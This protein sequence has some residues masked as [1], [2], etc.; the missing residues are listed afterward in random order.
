[1]KTLKDPKV[2]ESGIKPAHVFMPLGSAILAN[3]IVP[4]VGAFL[5][6]GAIG[7]LLSLVWDD[8]E[9]EVKTRI[10]VF[11]SF[12]FDEDVM[13]VQ[14]IRNIGSFDG[15][16]PVSPNEW[17]EVEQKGDKAIK[18]WIDEN[19]K[20][21]RCV[22]VLIGEKTSSSK[23]VNYEIERAWN[24]GK[25]LL[26]VHV[27]NLKCPK[28]GK[29]K[30]GQNPFDAFEFKSGDRLSSVVRCYDPSPSEVYKEIA[31]NIDEWVRVAIKEKR[32]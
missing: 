21:K 12:D 4:G 32:N 1:M 19:L 14:Q 3:A 5:S 31:K 24:T 10:P 27:H 2:R 28:T 11:Y 15:N 7:G 22:I 17:E 23:W 18:A 20:Y 8:E 13:R 9:E 30:K 26:G 16:R 6:G 25:A 29:S